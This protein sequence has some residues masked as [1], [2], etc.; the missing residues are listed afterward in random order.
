VFGRLFPVPLRHVIATEFKGSLGIN[1]A[2]IGFGIQMKS[3]LQIVHTRDI[4]KSDL[5]SF[6]ISLECS[7]RNLC[8]FLNNLILRIRQCFIALVKN[9]VRKPSMDFLKTC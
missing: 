5:N 8:S 2:A 7:L 6:Y 1:R 9:L 3:V 4:T